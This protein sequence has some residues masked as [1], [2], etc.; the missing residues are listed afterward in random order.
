MPLLALVEVVHGNLDRL[1]GPRGRIEGLFPQLR[2]VEDLLAGVLCLPDD[3][4]RALSDAQVGLTATAVKVIREQVA[5]RAARKDALAAE[6]RTAG[7]TDPS[8]L[9]AELLREELKLRR[10]RGETIDVPLRSNKPVL[11]AALVRARA[12]APDVPR[13]AAAPAA[14]AA[15]GG[16]EAL[17]APTD[18]VEKLVG[19]RVEAVWEDE[20]G[21]TDSGSPPP[22][23]PIGRAT[24]S[25]H[26]RLLMHF[27]DGMGEIIT[28][29]DLT[30][31]CA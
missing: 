29:P 2:R 16:G 5:A 9:T 4:R 26:D 22:P 27:D 13:P 1:E 15:G 6:K 8:K 10:E 23:S 24:N 21:S 31:P 7:T 14:A 20:D 30:T 17:I 12:A 18:G 28:L 25:E 3:E 11:L 19:Q